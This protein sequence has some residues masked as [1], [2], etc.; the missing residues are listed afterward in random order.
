MSEEFT[1]CP[2]V[3]GKANDIKAVAFVSPILSRHIRPL[4]ELPPFKP[5]DEQEGVLARFALRL[6]KLHGNR[7]SYVDFPLL[8]PGATARDGIPSLEVAYGQLNALNVPFEP[9]FGFD[10]DE[11]LW[12]IVAAQATKSGG[13]LLRLDREDVEFFQETVERIVGLFDRGLD[14][15]SF[16]V[17]IDRRTVSSRAEAIEASG[18][19]ANFIDH[20][21]RATSVRRVLIAGS[22]APK[23]VSLVD[24]DSHRALHRYELDLWAHLVSERLPIQAIFSDYGVI[25]PDFSDLSLATHINGKIRYTAGDKLHIHRGHSLRQLDKFEQYRVL[26]A[27]VVRSPY[28]KGSSF[29]YGDRYVYE[30]A[31]GHAGTG[32]PGTWVLVDQNH[33]ISL[34]ASQLSRLSLAVQNGASAESLL[35]QV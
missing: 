4:F 8:R 32:N 24:R 7:R 17:M 11:S 33:H 31:T 19:A 12:D 18:A 35:E 2:I 23:T 26:A 6:K 16:D 30:C 3:K 34:T 25:H 22:C 28:Y 10:R 15:S 21:C 14:L 29:S 13:L 20:L 9:V 27:D 5:T 1:Y